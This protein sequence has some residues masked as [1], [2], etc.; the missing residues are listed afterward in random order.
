MS[1]ARRVFRW[2]TN[3]ALQLLVVKW[4][5]KFC[6]LEDPKNK[7]FFG[8]KTVATTKKPPTFHHTG[9]YFIEILIMVYFNPHIYIYNW[10][11]KSPMYPKQPGLF[12][13]L[14]SRHDIVTVI[15][16]PTEAWVLHGTM[17]LFGGDT[18]EEDGSNCALATLLQWKMA[19]V[20]QRNVLILRRVTSPRRPWNLRHRY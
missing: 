4:I 18:L 5:L 1:V 14:L 17:N 12:S 7:P 10:V 15:H 13:M 11:G 20:Y 6:T 3:C 8:I 16:D 19:Q 2:F 9:Y